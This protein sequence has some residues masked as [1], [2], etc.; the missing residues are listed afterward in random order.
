MAIGKPLPWDVVMEPIYLRRDLEALGWTHTTIRRAERRGELH[1]IRRGAWSRGPAGSAREEHMALAR[2]ALPYC[3]PDTLMSHVTAAAFWGLPLPPVDL[4]RVWLTREGAGGGHVRADVHVVRAPLPEA[5]RALVDGVPVTA[6]ARTV[7]DVARFVPFHGGVMV[8]D[9]ALAQGLTRDDLLEANRTAHRWPGNAR[10]RNVAL[11]AD[12]RAESPYESW[13]RFLLWEMGL[14][15]AVP[16]FRITDDQGRE[17]ARVDFAIPELRM[18]IEYDGEG[19]YGELLEPGLTPQQAF[20]AEKTREAAI[21]E[22]GWWVV[23][24]TKTDVHDARRFRARMQQAVRMARQY[25]ARAA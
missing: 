20:A 13:V 12:P 3:A 6:L 23:R 18:V 14:P 19:K 21:R 2:G 25:A 7:N 4:S 9:A 15:E 1:R 17:V 16:Q 22:R 10:A 11:F 8:A 5:H 24:L